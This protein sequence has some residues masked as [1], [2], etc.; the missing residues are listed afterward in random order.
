MHA[1]DGEIETGKSSDGKMDVLGCMRRNVVACMR[2][3][4]YLMLMTPFSPFSS[5]PDHDSNK[6]P[7]KMYKT[8]RYAPRMRLFL[9]LY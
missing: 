2:V 8:G 4:V 5:I 3:V 1:T 6:V 7:R 9:L